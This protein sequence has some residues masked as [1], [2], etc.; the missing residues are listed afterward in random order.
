MATGLGLQTQRL[1]WL[2]TRR[3]GPWAVPPRNGD[4]L[5]GAPTAFVDRSPPA[6]SRMARVNLDLA[7]RGRAEAALLRVAFHGRAVARSSVRG[8]GVFLMGALAAIPLL[9]LMAGLLGL[10]GF[11]LL[12]VA[13]IA[14]AA[15]VAA[16]LPAGATR[17]LRLQR[18]STPA[19]LAAAPSDGG[20]VRVRGR[21]TA[22]RTVPALDGQPAVFVTVRATRHG[23]GTELHKAQDFLLDEGTGVPTR[24][25]V[26]HALLL[27]R[28]VRLF[29]SWNSPPLETFRWIP[30]GTTPVD[31]EQAALFPGDE[32]EVV[33]RVEMV[34]D[35]SL[36]DRMPRDTPLA[37]V[38][39]GTPDEPLLIQSLV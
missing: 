37:R 18:W 29:G 26:A 8:G 5:L 35:P 38:L 16:Q 12:G 24:V 17:A 31:L 23:R 6:L 20:R 34:V 11:L 33:G 39:H 10:G 4:R 7:F 14:K 25:R 28:P 13:A 9:P 1:R 15:S 36:V 32:V 19:A 3:L 27:D 30:A 21:I 2:R 22:G